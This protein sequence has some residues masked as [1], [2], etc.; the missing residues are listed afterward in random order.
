MQRIARQKAQRAKIEAL[1]KQRQIELKR[2]QAIQRAQAW[3]AKKPVVTRTVTKG[4]ANLARAKARALAQKKAALQ[5]RIDVVE[6]QLSAASAA[7]RNSVSQQQRLKKG[8]SAYNAQYQKTKAF[9]SKSTQL[10]SKLS[11]LKS[12]LASL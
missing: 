6:K 11:D 2:R 7:H 1:R 12:R 5:R 3:Q 10:R 9:A 8:T 4:P